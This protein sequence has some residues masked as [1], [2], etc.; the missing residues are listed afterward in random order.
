MKSLAHALLVLHIIAGTAA[1]VVGLVALAVRKPMG[2]S[3]RAHLRSG[4]L[5]LYSMA[6]VIGTATPPTLISFNAYF[7]G[8]TTVNAAPP[9]R[10]K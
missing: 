9:A 6:V 3:A 10:V 8:L 5:F 1:V 7:A 4:R 2:K